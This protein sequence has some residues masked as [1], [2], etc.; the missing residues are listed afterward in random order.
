MNSIISI[1]KKVKEYF[2]FLENEFGFIKTSEYQYVTEI[3]NEFVKNGLIIQIVYDGDIWMNI[4]KPKFNI[5][6]LLNEEKRIT[7]YDITNF[8]YYDV[9]NLDLDNSI[10]KSINSDKLSDKRLRYYSKLLQSNKEILNG[11]LKKLKW[12]FPIIRKLGFN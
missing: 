10:W 8:K 4:L 3:H 5:Q 7:D 11:N 12:Y 2:S 1:S 6:I 9:K